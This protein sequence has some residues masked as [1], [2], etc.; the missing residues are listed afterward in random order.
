MIGMVLA[1][2][3]LAIAA[4][5]ILELI[6]VQWNGD[7]VPAPNI[8]RTP[9]TSGS[10][11]PLSYVVLGDST[12]ISQGSDYK[13][14]FAALT[15]QELAKT[16]TVTLTNLGV[17]GARLGD[18]LKTQVS[19]VKQYKPDVILIAAG[20]NDVTHLT[21]SA[22][23]K[24]TLESIAKELIEQQCSVKIVLTGSPDMGAIPRFPQPLRSFAGTRSE[25]LNEV[26]LAV[27]E[28]R[29]LTFA[30]IAAQ[31]GTTIRQHPEW[32]AADK[33]HLKAE[34]YATWVPV[35]N[36]AISGALSQ[37]PDHC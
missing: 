36:L 24:G 27:V 10:G 19:L 14:G 34:G 5:V 28:H 6:Y 18:V 21:L 33:F 30:P 9:V 35:L 2:I 26:F 8:V 12:A 11:P 7:K 15:A 31:T 25:Q 4:F 17:S 16:H 32:F 29:E 23:A 37:Q 3:L 20:A 1:S 22:S 13:D